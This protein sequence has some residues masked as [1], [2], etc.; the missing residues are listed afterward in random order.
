MSRSQ[1]AGFWARWALRDAR[2]RWIQV[3]SISLLLALGVG[4]YSGMSSM[5]DW[6][7]SSARA[8]FGELRMH[9]LRL[10]LPEGSFVRQGALM[11]ALQ[12]SSPRAEILSAAER[13]VVPTQVD[14]SAA[15]RSIIVPGRLVGAPVGTRVDTRDVTLGRGLTGADDGRPAAELEQNFAQHYDL[16]ASGVIRLPGGR[17]LRYVGQ[18]GAPEYF[19]VTTPGADFGAE[20]N[21]AVLFT[22]LRTA[23]RLGG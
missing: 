14:A 18:A 20:A 11:D 1:R 2:S 5:R 4:M 3:L 15:G 21:F 12:R 6:R 23:Q 7:T 19:I 16:P 13:L 17:S 8:S 22:T 9:D 10:S